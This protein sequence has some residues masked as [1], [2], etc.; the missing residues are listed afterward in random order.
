M[1]K[2]VLIGV[3]VL[4]G[5]WLA[6][7]IGCMAMAPK[8]DTAEMEKAMNE[9]AKQQGSGAPA[10]ETAAAPSGGAEGTQAGNL[11]VVATLP[12]NAVA[13]DPMGAPGYH[14]EDGSISVMV[15]ELD[16]SAPADMA[17]SK[18]DI[19]QFAFKKWKT[20]KASPDG[21]ELTWDGIGIDMSGKEYPTYA[22][23]VVKKIG[24]KRYRCSGAVKS[25]SHLP[26]NLSICQSL[27]AGG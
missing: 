13:N 9:A 20:S 3:G 1:M 22:F 21:W 16:A 14:S 26:A 19:E 24:D 11:P 12:S 4:F 23:E 18:A 8:V 6:T 7:C 2:K 15:S 5:L 10:G 27:K 17:K 25:E